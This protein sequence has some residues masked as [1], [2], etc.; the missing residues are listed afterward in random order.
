MTELMNAGNLDG[1]CASFTITS[2]VDK[3]EKECTKMK[4]MTELQIKQIYGDDAPSVMSHKE[5]QGF[6]EPDPNCPGKLLYFMINDQ[7][8]GKPTS[9]AFI[10]LPCYYFPPGRWDPKV[11]S[12][13]TSYWR[14]Y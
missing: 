7:R 4:P 9:C 5:A 12:V 2:S 6:T 13:L 11:E 1:F 8:P 3:Y 10:P 14:L